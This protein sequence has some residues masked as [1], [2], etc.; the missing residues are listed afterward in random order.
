MMI[1]QTVDRVKKL[2]LRH[3]RPRRRQNLLVYEGSIY[4][5]P[6]GRGIVLEDEPGEPHL[7]DWIE[8][9]LTKSTQHRLTSSGLSTRL[10]IVV[11]DVGKRVEP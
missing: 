5:R 11:E 3:R 2:K 7:D 10:Y 1:R 8:A 4:V 9:G 6:I